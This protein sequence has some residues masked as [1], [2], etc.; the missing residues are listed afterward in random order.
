MNL[1]IPYLH[2]ENKKVYIHFAS[3]AI[4]DTL[5]WFPYAEE[6]GKKHKCK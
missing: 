6:F 2:K 1:L 3:N 4:G 5:A